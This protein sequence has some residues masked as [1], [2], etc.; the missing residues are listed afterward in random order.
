MEFQ[1]AWSDFVV[2]IRNNFLY[3]KI[4]IQDLEDIRNF[5]PIWTQ[6]ADWGTW[7]MKVILL[8]ENDS[9]ALPAMLL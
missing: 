5:I 2:P 8:S 4:L 6:K 9:K 3:N 7:K 1:I